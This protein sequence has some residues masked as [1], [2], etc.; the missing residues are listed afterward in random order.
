M[1]RVLAYLGPPVTVADLLLEPDSSLVKQVINP[2]MMG[3]LNL[4]GFGLLAW[5]EHSHEP[6]APFE[7]RI[8]TLPTFDSNL[9][10]LSEKIRCTGLLA[11]V[12]GVVYEAQDVAPQNLHPFL[13]PNA[14]F[15]MAMNGDLDRFSEMRIDVAAAVDSDWLGS[16][17]GTTDTE[18]LYALILSRL[19]TP[20]DGS[21]GP[22]DVA[23]AVT[24]ALED[25][26]AIRSKRGI[27]TQS[28]VNLVLGNGRWLVA[29]R[30]TYDYGWYPAEDSFFAAERRHDFLTMWITKG[31]NYGR[32]QG[33][34][35][36]GSDAVVDS[37]VV[38]SE[39]LTAEAESWFEVPAY[40]I[41]VVDRRADGMLE[42]ETTELAA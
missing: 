3:M 42:I 34:W 5:D 20:H 25:V 41:T 23:L 15:A 18:M 31:R 1:C 38:A 14:P 37:L 39:P 27:D 32:H 36:M 19:S 30:F 9:K 29:T 2:Q 16:V 24:G 6:D 26:R 12:R 13:F 11:H 35:G 17:R 21:V 40:S 4:G 28:A 22:R 8:P 33:S 10:S 7:F